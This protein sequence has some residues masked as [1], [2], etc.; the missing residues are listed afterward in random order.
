MRLKYLEL[1]FIVGLAIILFFVGHF[2]SSHFLNSAYSETSN[3]LNLSNEIINATLPQ[4]KTHDNTIYVIWSGNVGHGVD[5]E[6]Q[7]DIFITE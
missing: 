2:P 1:S 5:N 3:I 6:L 7:S 4:I